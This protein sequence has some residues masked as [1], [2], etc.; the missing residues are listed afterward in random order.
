MK[1]TKRVARTERIK[2]LLWRNHIYQWQIAQEVGV[3]TRLVSAVVHGERK[4]RRV[5]DAIAKAVH[6]PVER[7]FPHRGCQA[8][9]R[10]E[11]Q[12]VNREVQSGSSLQRTF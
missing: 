1:T 3:S 10:E 7:L 11:P 4:S 5:Q 6:A 8:T 2:L 9:Q 12:P